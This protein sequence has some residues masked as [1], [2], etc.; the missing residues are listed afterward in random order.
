MVDGLQP[1]AGS[2][3]SSCALR[4]RQLGEKQ[5]P[6]VQAAV[7]GG[8]LEPSAGSGETPRVKRASNPNKKWCRRWD[9]N[10]HG[11]TPKGF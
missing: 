2:G 7:P 1:P 5:R 3:T 4:T 8:G 11:I 6:V 10:P 9:S